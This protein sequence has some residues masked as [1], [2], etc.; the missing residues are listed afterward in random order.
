MALGSG[1][2]LYDGT[3][4]AQY[5]RNHHREHEHNPKDAAICDAGNRLYLIGWM[6]CLQTEYIA[7]TKEAKLM[8]NTAFDVT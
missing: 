2:N 5:E 3:G 4:E 8:Q 6:R 1:M 7:A